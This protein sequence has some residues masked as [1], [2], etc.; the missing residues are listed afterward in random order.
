MARRAPV[1]CSCQACPSHPKCCLQR[2]G[3]PP[4]SPMDP[5]GMFASPASRGCHSLQLLALP[6]AGSAVA[7]AGREHLLLRLSSE[8]GQCPLHLAYF[9]CD[10]LPQMLRV[11]A[12]RNGPCPHL[13]TR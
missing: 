8:E 5:G 6:L 11:W 4:A 2:L 12:G 13:S 7:V 3:S 9:C 10:L 1:P